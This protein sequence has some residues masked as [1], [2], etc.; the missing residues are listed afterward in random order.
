[1]NSNEKA[2]ERLFEGIYNFTAPMP[3]G[4]GKQK[5]FY[6]QFRCGMDVSG[7]HDK[8]GALLADEIPLVQR[9]HVASGRNVSDVY[10]KILGAELPPDNP[11]ADKK[12]AYEKARQLLNS[13]QYKS[14]REAR[15][16]YNKAYLR[17]CR[18]KNDSSADP[19]DVMEAK[20]DE[21][22]AM[23]D[24]IRAGKNEME[25]ALAT[26]DAYERFTP[27]AVFNKAGQVFD[28]ASTQKT[29]QGYYE[30]DFVPQNWTD[31]KNLSWENVSVQVSRQT[32]KTDSQS[33]ATEFSRLC[34]FSGGWW[35]WKYEDKATE[36]QKRQ[37]KQA[38]SQMST[39]DLSLS[40]EIA[41]VQVSR[42]W[43]NEA[44]LSYSE[45]FLK[46]EDAGA[47][48]S[49]ELLGEGVMQI[50]PTA[51][52]LARNVRIYN[53]FSEEEKSLIQSVTDGCSDS[54]SY[55]PFCSTRSSHTQFH[56][57][58]SESERKKYGDVSCLTLGEKP[59]LIGI[60]NS[61]MSP[62]FPEMPG[63]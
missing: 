17:Y 49:G 36:Q 1:M 48:C 19:A 26:V 59:Q 28:D 7:F 56:E 8:E 61:I 35:F 21:Q 30:T 23:E 58:I 45:A 51:F 53:Q 27:Q 50:A 5:S 4:N 55:G 31:A 63:K 18:L 32:Y 24:L 46:N 29:I 10:Q 3:D 43:F 40:M 15:R 12:A 33:Q 44:L 14:Y 34:D 41:V 47:I 13:E 42:P 38:N 11:P 62:K 9:D 54:L 25:S 16:A 39:S 6:T 2:A 57:E 52:V 60:I 22:E 37:V 20:M